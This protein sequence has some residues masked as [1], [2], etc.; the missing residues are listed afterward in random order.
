MN[1]ADLF[2]AGKRTGKEAGEIARENFRTGTAAGE[3]VKKS[4][5][6]AGETLTS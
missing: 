4:G 6:E 5:K 3:R 1:G 2:N